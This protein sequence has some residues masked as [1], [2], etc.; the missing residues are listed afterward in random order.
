MGGFR[1][2]TKTEATGTAASAAEK[3]RSKHEDNAKNNPKTISFWL[4][5][6]N[7]LKVQ[8]KAVW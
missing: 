4:A 6:K 3:T 8:M 7:I 1:G 2:A 5:E